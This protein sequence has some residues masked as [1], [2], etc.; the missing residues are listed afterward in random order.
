MIAN[1]YSG[2]GRD[3]GGSFPCIDFLKHV[4]RGLK[5]GIIAEEMVLGV[6]A[7]C[8]HPPK[9]KDEELAD[10]YYGT[11]TETDRWMIYGSCAMFT[12]QDH[13]QHGNSSARNHI[14]AQWPNH[15]MGSGRRISDIQISKGTTFEICNEH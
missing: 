8:F 6:G 11:E 2:F 7:S 14:S 12:E 3:W 4:L 10:S 1:S 13:L 9:K 5:Q 15:Y